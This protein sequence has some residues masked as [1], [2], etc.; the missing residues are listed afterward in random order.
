MAV[1]TFDTMVEVK[2][3]HALLPL[4]QLDKTYT[5]L[6]AGS[7]G[8]V[9]RCV[10][11][12]C[13][14]LNAEIEANP[15]NFV[16]RLYTRRM[17]DARIRLATFLAVPTGDIALVTNVASGINTILRNIDWI[18]GD[19]LILP[20]TTYSTIAQN[21]NSLKGPRIVS[22]PLRFPTSHREILDAFRSLLRQVKQTLGGTKIV[23]LFDSIVSCPGVVMP[24]K[25]MVRICREEGA[26]SLVDAA[27]SIGQDP[28]IDLANVQPD[29][30][31]SNCSKWL[32]AR[33]GSAALYVPQRNQHHIK[34]SV[35]PGLKLPPTPE[36]EYPDFAP[37]FYWSGSVDLSSLLSVPFALDFR[38]SIGGEEKI[39]TYCHELAIA[40]GK[41]LAE[42]LQTQVMD[43]E[44]HSGEL[45]AS[46]VNVELPLP[47][48][49][50]PTGEII[51]VLDTKLLVDHHV[52]AAHFYHNDR[53]W[54][55]A[56]AQVFNELDD[57][58]RLGFAL[59][60]ICRDIS[61]AL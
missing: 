17:Y 52:Y 35:P 56:S 15:D 10:L 6:N 37:L 4:F 41:R 11:D 61:C 29:F 49:L 60:A 40:G 22:M 54:V 51:D 1:P 5:N 55:R 46:M 13:S 59:V 33:R 45:I 16:R 38:T 27:H 47:G 57:F 53:W 3:G 9:P 50:K 39:I 18:E 2:F 8:A 28:A 25:Q 30:W 43:S 26:L 23:A 34:H 31:A 21:A 48:S 7:F 32:F 20:D 44:E 42:I 24:W 14:T 58:V 19:V 36:E 12:S